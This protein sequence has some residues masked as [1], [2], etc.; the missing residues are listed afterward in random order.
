M[1]KEKRIAFFFLNCGILITV[2]DI[3]KTQKGFTLL[4]LMAV[5][6]ILS[7]LIL[8]VYPPIE[9]AIVKSRT[10][11]SDAQI[12]EI[13][14]GAKNWVADHIEELPDEGKNIDVTVGSLQDGGYIDEDLKDPKT[15]E[16]IPRENK[17]RIT[18]VGKQYQYEYI[19]VNTNS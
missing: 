19:G 6:V 17:I 16:K 13:K 3:M 11:S 9:N 1:M 2:G 4:E 15:N 7:I 14:A 12:A 8:L 10:G 18:N 5:I